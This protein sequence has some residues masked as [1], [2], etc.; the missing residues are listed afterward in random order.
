MI[1]A[2]KARF[3]HVNALHMICEAGHAAHCAYL[4][5]RGSARV[6]SPYFNKGKQ[7]SIVM[8]KFNAY[9]NMFSSLSRSNEYETQ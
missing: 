5:L 6:S 8:F 9:R 2:K 7:F 3:A 4:L 1:L